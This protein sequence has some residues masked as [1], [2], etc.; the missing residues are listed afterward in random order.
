MMAHCKARPLNQW[1]HHHQLRDSLVKQK[2]SAPHNMYQQKYYT[3]LEKRSPLLLAFDCY[4]VRVFFSPPTYSLVS[5]PW[6]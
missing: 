3:Q 2:D 4:F 1:L 5:Y 6:F